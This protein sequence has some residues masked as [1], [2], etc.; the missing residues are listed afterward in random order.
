MGSM[1]IREELMK[2]AGWRELLRRAEKAAGTFE[3]DR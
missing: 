2:V 3:G 1:W